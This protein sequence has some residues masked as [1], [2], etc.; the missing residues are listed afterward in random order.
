MNFAEFIFFSTL[1]Y[2]GLFYLILVLFRFNIKENMPKMAIFALVLSFVSNT[3]QTESLRTLS[4]LIHITL[5]ILFAISVLRVNLFHAAVMMITGQVIYMMTQWIII[6]WVLE[7]GLLPA[8]EPY[9]S[10]AYLIQAA[11]ALIMLLIALITFVQKGGFSFIDHNSR[12]KRSKIFVA[13]NRLFI[14]FLLFS[15]AVTFVANLLFVIDTNPPLLLI[16][17][18][19]AI[20]LI[21]IVYTCMKR[22]DQTDGGIV[23]A[24][25]RKG[26]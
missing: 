3:L 8:I 24:Q 9:T 2:V 13:E 22:D 19:M 6:V 18:F 5:Y 4:P 25:N 1:E 7:S 21:G 26:H 16:S 15:V 14:F 10:N 11:T 12:I 20:A 17:V 23:G